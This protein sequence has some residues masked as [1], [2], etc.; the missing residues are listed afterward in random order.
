LPRS[1][2]SACVSASRTSRPHA[3]DALIISLLAKDPAQRPACASETA[4]RLRGAL[5]RTRLAEAGRIARS[6]T[7]PKYQAVAL[8]K[9]VA[10]AVAGG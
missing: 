1:V 7:N 6:I 10:K 8:R 2:G 9:V 4:G 5:N 3:L